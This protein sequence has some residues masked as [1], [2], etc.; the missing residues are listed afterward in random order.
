MMLAPAFVAASLVDLTESTH[1]HSLKAL[2]QPAA[3]LYPEVNCSGFLFL[4][5]AT[6]GR[7]IHRYQYQLE[8]GISQQQDTGQHLDYWETEER[9]QGAIPIVAILHLADSLYFSI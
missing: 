9:S 2:I 7:R 5:T 1:Q 6:L 3:A 4:A 8:L